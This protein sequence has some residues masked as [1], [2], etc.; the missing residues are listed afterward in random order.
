MEN[1]SKFFIIGLLGLLFLVGIAALA[2]FNKNLSLQKQRDKLFADNQQLAQQFEASQQ[3]A[4]RLKDRLTAMNSDL[5]RL[6]KEKNDFQAKFEVLSRERDELITTVK[7]QKQEQA[8]SQPQE[9]RETPQQQ[10]VSPAEDTYWAGI[11]KA[12][13]E[14]EL[15]LGDLRKD[16]NAAQSESK[17]LQ[18][19]KSTLQLDID[20]LRR[21][22]KDL[23]GQ[24][25]Y[26]KKMMDSF[27]RDLVTERNDKMKIQEA[28]KALKAE[29]ELLMRQ[30]K[31]VNSRKYVLEKKIQEL[32]EDKSAVE[33][34]FKDMDSMLTEK[35]SMI[36]NLKTELEG[37]RSVP[38]ESEEA[39]VAPR[40]ESV[41]LPPIVVR[42]QAEQPEVRIQENTTVLGGKVLAINKDSNFVI[43]DLGEDAGVKVGDA[44]RVYREEK[45]IAG[46]EVI[47]TRKNIAACDIKS[48]TAP[49]KIGDTVR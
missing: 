38:V 35:V 23:E 30:V 43:I 49:I 47:Q 11:L 48:E 6:T 40:K 34:K 9:A 41:E 44:F 36:G 18:S 24:V 14:L 39:V 12:K 46:V 33:R 17:Q 2:T 27:T 13:T 7:K 45:A 31:S 1:K 5:Q 32:Q 15:R 3:D 25:A 28:I 42:P 29:N 4:K 8:F 21:E 10:A 37:I 16:L 26:N 19:E 22:K 20:T